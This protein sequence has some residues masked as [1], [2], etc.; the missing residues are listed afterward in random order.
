MQLQLLAFQTN[1]DITNRRTK[2]GV[3]TTLRIGNKIIF[4]YGSKKTKM[5][6]AQF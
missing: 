5:L 3:E 6:K 1:L 2:D 4:L